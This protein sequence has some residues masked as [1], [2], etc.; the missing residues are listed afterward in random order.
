V[1][2][3]V[4]PPLLAFLR[5]SPHHNRVGRVIFRRG[6]FEPFS[7]FRQGLSSR[8]FF[9]GPLPCFC[10]GL[11][12]AGLFSLGRPERSN[13]TFLA[14]VVCPPFPTR[15]VF[16]ILFPPFFFF[17]SV[18]RCFPPPAPP[19]SPAV[20]PRVEVPDTP[21]SVSPQAC[22]F[23]VFFF[24]CCGFLCCCFWCCVRQFLFVRTWPGRFPARRSVS[25]F[26]GFSF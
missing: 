2:H 25:F 24:F 1:R 7:L 18:F 13:G 14:S 26:L 19:S 21:P 6:L 11:S 23:L 5:S 12:L 9:Y 10:V 20:P 17:F 4:L 15:V 16:S 22:F 3:A 8:F